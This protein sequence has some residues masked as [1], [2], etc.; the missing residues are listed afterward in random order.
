MQQ[1]EPP[2]EQMPPMGDMQPQGDMETEP[3]N[4]GFDQ[5]DSGM[6]APM[7]NMGQDNQFDTNFDA[8]VEADEDKDPKKFIQQ[9][10]GKLSQSLR[11]FNEDNGQPDV[12]LNKYVAGMIVKQAM[13]GLSQDDADEILDKVKSDEDFSTEDGQSDN[14]QMTDDQQSIQNDNNDGNDNQNTFQQPNESVNRFH[15]KIDEIVNNILHQTNDK[16]EKH[17][18]QKTNDK[19]SFRKKPF[20]SPNFDN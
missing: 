13:E 5:N 14:S 9:L 6:N 11:K 1:Q 4:G 8:G 16:E 19:K 18:Y 3:M 10:T 12:D 20:S 2:M 17:P 7:D 15:N